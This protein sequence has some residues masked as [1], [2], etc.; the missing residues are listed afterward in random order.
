[1]NMLV[2]LAIISS[3][4]FVLFGLA[5]AWISALRGVVRMAGRPWWIAAAGVGRRALAAA[6]GRFMS[7]VSGGFIVPVVTVGW[8]GAVGGRGRLCAAW[9]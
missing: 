2:I 3:N 8:V 1:M 4:S 9:G 5:I 7:G 6:D